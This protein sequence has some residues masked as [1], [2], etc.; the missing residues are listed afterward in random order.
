[1][2]AIDTS[3]SW[4][5]GGASGASK[6]PTSHVATVSPSPSTGRGS[7]RWSVGIAVSIAVAGSQPTQPPE[8][9]ASIAGLAAARGCVQVGPP[10]SPSGSTSGVAPVL[11]TSPVPVRE[12]AQPVERWTTLY[13]SE[14]SDAASVVVQSS[15]VDPLLVLRARSEL[16]SRSVPPS[17]AMPPPL[18]LARLS[19]TVALR[20]RV[21]PPP[22]ASPPPRALWELQATVSPIWLSERV[23]FSIA[24]SPA[25]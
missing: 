7:P 18:P 9:P 25:E 17:R 5:T 13:P 16:R 1:M 11:T 20:R 21:V 22:T 10:E 24:V 12:V 14:T 6:A 15:C 3:R 8:S 19:A 23:E 4:K 2:P